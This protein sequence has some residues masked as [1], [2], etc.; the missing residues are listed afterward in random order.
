MTRM[1]QWTMILLGGGMLAAMLLVV[2]ATMG[3]TGGLRHQ[4]LMGD[5][6]QHVEASSQGNTSRATVRLRVEG[7]VCYG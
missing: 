1:R 3:Q 7:M 5:D 4:L 2:F 6:P